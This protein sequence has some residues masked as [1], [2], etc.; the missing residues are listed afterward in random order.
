MPEVLCCGCS[1]STNYT[2]LLNE[3][4]HVNVETHVKNGAGLDIIEDSLKKWKDRAGRKNIDWVIVQLPTPLR[5]TPHVKTA[6]FQRALV[7]NIKFKGKEI[8]ERDLINLYLQRI[9]KIGMYH[10]NIVFFL[11]NTAGYP[12]RHPYDFGSGIENKVISHIEEN[13][14]KHVT[15]NLEGV[16]GMC[17]VETKMETEDEKERI[18]TRMVKIQ[19]N[20][21]G[22][23]IVQNPKNIFIVNGHPNKVADELAASLIDEYIKR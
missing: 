1:W 2:K 16:P 17:R 7:K 8:A 10:E 14:F 3:K 5:V 6:D 9:S 4:W 12:F 19:K 22:T 18:K 11:Y 15:L 13:G 21:G 20:Y 23:Y